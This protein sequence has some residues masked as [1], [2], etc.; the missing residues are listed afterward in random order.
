M[1]GLKAKAASAALAGLLITLPADEGLR[2]TPYKDVGGLLTVCYGHTRNVQNRS[3]SKEACL[4]LLEVDT[5][6]HMRRV[7]G[8]MDSK[9]REDVPA[10]MLMAFTSM[11][12][13]TGG[14]CNSRS[15]REF[16]KGND[17]ESCK[18]LAFNERN[19]P[20]W[21]FVD[22]KFYKG[23]HN[24]RIREMNTCYDSLLKIG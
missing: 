5:L 8:C 16:N 20:A 4:E 21:S 19:M 7:E 22:G 18:A 12:F 1:Q 13:N 10:G 17:V 2:T 6:T 24:R 9:R 23:L 11:D 3:Y 15:R 14:W